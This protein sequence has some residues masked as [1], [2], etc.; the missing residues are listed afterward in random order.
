MRGG[1]QRRNAFRT[2]PSL[3]PRS[4]PFREENPSEQTTLRRIFRNVLRER[5]ATLVAALKG[6]PTYS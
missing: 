6:R 4:G 3:D 1:A 5:A 2:S